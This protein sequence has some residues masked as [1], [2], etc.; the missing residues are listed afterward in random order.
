MNESRNFG[1]DVIIGHKRELLHIAPVIHE[2]Q[3]QQIFNVRIIS[4]Q[5][6]GSEIA[7]ALN[8]F[9][10]QSDIDWKIRGTA[11]DSGL[12]LSELSTL[13]S[14]LWQRRKPD[15][16]LNFGHGVQSFSTTMT[17]FQNQIPTANIYDSLRATAHRKTRRYTSQ[18]IKSISIISELLFTPSVDSRN[19]L[20]HEGISENSIYVVGSTLSDSRR[21]VSEKFTPD[22]FKSIL[23]QTIHEHSVQAMLECKYLLLNL[24]SEDEIELYREIIAQIQF[25]KFS[26]LPVILVNDEN[27]PRRIMSKFESIYPESLILPK[28]RYHQRLAI[29]Q[30]ASCVLS[31]H[32]DT[33]EEC[34]T[35]GTKAIMFDNANCCAELVTSGSVLAVP[36]QPDE[37]VRAILS[38]LE[39]EKKRIKQEISPQTVPQRQSSSAKVV[40]A[41]SNRTNETVQR[42]RTSLLSRQAG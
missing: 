4:L 31:N 24:N 14:E 40:Q 17:A 35:L 19:I 1:V 9:S 20:I 7:E 21:I 37:Q 33:L 27:H 41:I 22:S 5:Q 38:C 25:E 3:K 28:L 32:E 39:S 34:T 10:L 12:Y 30:R 42:W 29:L 11:A 8:L 6:P 2:L 23:L 15:W 13:L 26:L 16:V 36:Q 18:A